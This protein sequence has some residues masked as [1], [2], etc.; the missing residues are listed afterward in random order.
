MSGG[1]VPSIS[2]MAATGVEAG[3]RG[4]ASAVVEVVAGGRGG[5]PA[6]IEEA[7]SA[8][9]RRQSPRRRHATTAGGHGGGGGRECGQAPAV[10]EETLCALSKW[11]ELVR[12]ILP[13]GFVPDLGRIF[14]SGDQPIPLVPQPN[15][16]E[17]GRPIPS[18]LIPPTKY[19]LSDQDESSG[20]ITPT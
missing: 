14:L 10:A 9:E 6:V 13:N 15:T 1:M 3:G 19:Y 2:L 18:H 11:D 16:S 20:G 17:N 4:G 7:A 12:S 5:A 8:D